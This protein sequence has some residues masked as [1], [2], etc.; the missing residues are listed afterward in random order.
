MTFCLVVR[1]VLADVFQ[2][3]RNFDSCFLRVDIDTAAPTSSPLFTRHDND[4][5]GHQVCMKRSNALT[6]LTL[7]ESRRVEVTRTPPISRI[8][9][10]TQHTVKYTN[11]LNPFHPSTYSLSSPLR[12]VETRLYC[13]VERHSTVE[14]QQGVVWSFQAPLISSMSCC[15]SSTSTSFLFL[16]LFT[17]LSVLN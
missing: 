17:Y 15:L 10:N 9:D 5:R 11:D 16:L 7:T 12:L 14:Y 6:P 13:P 8:L 4:M 3:R 1:R 2:V